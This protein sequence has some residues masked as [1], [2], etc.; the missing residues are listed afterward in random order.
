MA[1]GHRQALGDEIDGDHAG[2]AMPRDASAHLAHGPEPE[3]GDGPA[4]RDVRVLDACHAVGS[5]SEVQEALVG[6]PSGTFTGP[7]CACRTRQVL[8][9]SARWRSEP[10][11]AVDV[12]R[13]IASV[14]SSILGSGTDSTRTSRLPCQVTAFMTARFRGA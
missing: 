7:Y 2:A 1:L 3:E 8:G 11:I 12:M 14:G 4:V 5:R 13:T 9:L 6:G 10:Q